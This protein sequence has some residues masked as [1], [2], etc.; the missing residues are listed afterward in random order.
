MILAVPDV[1]I[2]ASNENAVWT[3]HF[4]HQRITVRPITSHAGARNSRNNPGAQIDCADRVVFR[5]DD[6]EDVLA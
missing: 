6:I 4:A 1:D 2:P 3:I 5:V